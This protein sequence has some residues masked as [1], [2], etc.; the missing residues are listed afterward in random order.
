MKYIP[1]K[2]LESYGMKTMALC[3]GFSSDIMEILRSLGWI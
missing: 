1:V 3:S 2:Y